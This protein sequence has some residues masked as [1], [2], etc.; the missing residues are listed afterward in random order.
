[1]G[2]AR[3]GLPAS[4]HQT[5]LQD[6]LGA[7]TGIDRLTVARQMR[8]IDLSLWQ[9]ASSVAH[10]VGEMAARRTDL[11]RPQRAVVIDAAWLHDIGKLTL[12]RETLFKPGPLTDAEWDEMRQHPA[13]G[14]AYLSRSHDLGPIAPLVRQHH[15][16]HD[17]RGYPGGMHGS[18]IELGARMIGVADAYDAMTNWRPYRPIL[19]HDDAIAELVKGSG[20]QFD[21][22]IV[23]L[24]IRVAAAE[25][26]RTTP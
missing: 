9:H 13:R 3:I 17:G 26:M 12:P 23:S 10:L 5:A 25:N 11:S 6:L 8:N 14:A 4:T 15:E 19:S 2:E 16:W 18:Q 22:T 21:P 1:M 24:F 7:P 20:T